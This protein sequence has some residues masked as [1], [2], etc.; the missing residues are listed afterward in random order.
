MPKVIK[1]FIMNSR[2]FLVL[3]FLLTGF[4]SSQFNAQLQTD[5]SKNKNGHELK[6][7]PFSDRI[8]GGGNLSFNIYDGWILLDAAPYLG[9]KISS[10]FSSGLGAKYI[11]RGFPEMDINES[12]YGVNIFSRYQFAKHFMIH[13]EY[14]LLRVYELNYL[15]PNYGDF[16]CESVVQTCKEC[17]R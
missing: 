6:D 7:L 3:L 13:A 2:L 12:Y 9:Y 4:Y 1:I 14:E 16:F 15:Q 8:F 17:W 11:Y 5:T 10:K